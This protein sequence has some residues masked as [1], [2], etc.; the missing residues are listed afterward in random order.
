MASVSYNARERRLVFESLCWPEDAPGLAAAID[1]FAEPSTALVVD[2]TRMIYVPTEVATAI[3]AACRRAEAQGCRVHVWT[4]PGT[5]TARRLPAP[6]DVRASSRAPS[7]APPP[8][9][10]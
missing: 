8:A 5:A 2:L 3:D 6:R 7:T 1:A 10:V 9:I 4:E